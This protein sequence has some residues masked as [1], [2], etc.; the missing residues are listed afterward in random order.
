[1]M[2]HKIEFPKVM[3]IT[4]TY[5]ASHGKEITT[6]Y[7]VKTAAA[8]ANWYAQQWSN[9]RCTHLPYNPDDGKQAVVKRRVN[10]I[11]K[12]YLP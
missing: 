8:A 10:K 7:D 12:Q 5:T 9:K 2:R 4:Y 11:F 1:M 6:Y 3:R